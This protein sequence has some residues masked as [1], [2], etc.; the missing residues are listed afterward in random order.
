M[1][2]NS[3]FLGDQR[4]RQK[5]EAFAKEVGGEVENPKSESQRLPQ[6][7]VVESVECN[8]SPYGVKKKH[9]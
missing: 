8:R 1:F 4:D 9:L 2:L 3:Y 7:A 5:A 6:T